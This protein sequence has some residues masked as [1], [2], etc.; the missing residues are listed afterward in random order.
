MSENLKNPQLE[1]TLDGHFVR[2][3]VGDHIEQAIAQVKNA[4]RLFQMA[5][6]D[7]AQL[8]H[9]TLRDKALLCEEFDDMMQRLRYFTMF[10]ISNVDKARLNIKE[11]FVEAWD[12]ENKSGQKDAN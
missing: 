3:A 5:I 7:N 2:Q 8:K 1:A 9:L 4:K 12:A 6:G 11:A 10:R